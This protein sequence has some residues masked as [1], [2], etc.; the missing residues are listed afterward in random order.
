MK[1]RKSDYPIDAR[2]LNRWSPRAMSTDLLEDDQLMRLFEAARWAPSS[3]NEQPW[4]FIYGKRG[5][6]HWDRLFNLLVP[7]NQSWAKN[8]SF[9]IL[10]ISRNRF[11][12]T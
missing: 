6:K 8:S 3:Y 10:V 9:L 12:A 1:Q 2:I 4:C 5:T 7:Y 11:T